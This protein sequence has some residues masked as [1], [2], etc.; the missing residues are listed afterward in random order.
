MTSLEP[1]H[2][3]P[4]YAEEAFRFLTELGF[5]LEDRWVTGG[6]SVRDGWRI[7]Y[8]AS[9]VSLTVTYLDS[10]LELFFTR[11]GVSAEYL[12]ID[13]E[14]FARRSGLY[15]N[16][17]PPQKLAGAIDRVATDVRENYGA[18]LRGEATTWNRIKH[19]LQ[20]PREKRL[21]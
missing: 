19:C 4:A 20:A 12:F 21:P 5:R 14:L 2:A 18:I 7:S 8:T 16:M 1:I 15:G 3:S 11:S 13:R 17:F 9:S 10:Q 6:H